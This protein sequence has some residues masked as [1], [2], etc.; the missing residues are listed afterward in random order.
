M[1]GRRGRWFPV[2][3]LTLLAILMLLCGM[4]LA[5]GVSGAGV[6]S[7]LKFIT[8]D[9]VIT[10][11]LFQAPLSAGDDSSE[12][13]PDGD[14]VSNADELANSTDPYNSDTDGD[15]LSDQWEIENGLDPLHSA[16][17]QMVTGASSPSTIDTD[18][19]G[20]PDE[21]ETSYGLNPTVGE[22]NDGREGDPDADRLFNI[23]EW[24]NGTNP[25][26]TDG[27]GDG[28]PDQWE[29]ENG[30]NPNDAVGDNGGDGDLDQ[31]GLTNLQ[32]LANHTDASNPDTDADS[33]PDQ[34]EIGFGL[35][36]LDNNGN[37]GALG[38]PDGDGYH[39]ADEYL[40]ITNPSLAD[41]P[42]EDDDDGPTTKHL[43]LPDMRN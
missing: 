7:N 11:A 33:L 40:N 32:E 24:A 8:M 10:G 30:S 6:Q 21:W 37:N 14:G 39:N 2:S 28:L 15:G 18:G 4:F 29:V 26:N 27:D 31:D 3:V 22:G 16:G 19:D 12:D 17:Y 43:F 41:E 25:T 9:R 1:L 35:N 20:L 34:W 13:D 23:D 5:S 36:P 42:A 38:D